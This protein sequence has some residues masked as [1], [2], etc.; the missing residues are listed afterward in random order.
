MLY[1]I[2]IGCG[3][4]WSHMV[5]IELAVLFP[6]LF[7]LFGGWQQWYILILLICV[8]LGGWY[9]GERDYISRTIAWERLQKETNNFSGSYTVT[10]RVD[11]IMYTSDLSITYRLQIANI[12]NRSPWNRESLED[13]NIGI[14]LEIPNNLHISINDTIEYSGKIVWVIDHPLKG[15]AGYAWYHRVYG[16]STIPIFHRIT[17]GEIGTLGKI[18]QWA[19]S[20]IFKWFPGNIAGI[21]LGMTIGNIE[22]LSSETKKSFTSAGITHILVVSGSNIAFVIVILTSLLRYIP[23]KKWLRIS[24]VT[25]FVFL[26]GSLVGWDMP[27]VRAVAMWLIIYMAIEWG[28]RASSLAVLFLV[29]WGILLY[30]PLALVFD[31]GFGL[32]FAWTLGILLWHPPLQKI[33]ENKYTPKFVIDIVSVTLAASAGSII[34]IIYHFNTIPLWTLASNIL[35][36][37]FLGWILLASV[38]YLIFALVWGWILYL[39]GWTIYLP[40]AYIMWVGQ[41]FGNSSNYTIDEKIAE[42]IALFL[43]GIMMVVILSMEKRKLLQS[44]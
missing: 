22:L 10:G 35:I 14:F 12:A 32:S 9:L 20:V 25:L 24:I 21:V 11:Q 37:G 6:L 33:L 23:I 41:F 38:L 7:V 1:A 30:S 44:K 15:F 19:K 17:I 34:A 43:V 5:C 26:Y 36:S 31:A 3:I 13:K 27:V 16:K 2:G 8:S 42:P 18:Q 40:T 4:V 39:W 28:N 29:G